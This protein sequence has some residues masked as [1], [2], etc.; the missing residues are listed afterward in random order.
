MYGGT[1]IRRLKNGEHACERAA[2]ANPGPTSR[3][4]LQRLLAILTPI[5]ARIYLAGMLTGTGTVGAAVEDVETVFYCAFSLD[6]RSEHIVVD[7][8]C[9]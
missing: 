4:H 9:L 3:I 7:G 5:A 6:G 1:V 2:A 8:L